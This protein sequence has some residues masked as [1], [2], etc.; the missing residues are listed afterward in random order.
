MNIILRQD[1]TLPHY[2]RYLRNHLD[3]RQIDRHG[4][5]EWSAR[6]PHNTFRFFLMEICR[7]TGL[8]DPTCISGDVRNRIT[9]VCAIIIPEIFETGNR[10]SEQTVSFLRVVGRTLNFSLESAHLSTFFSLLL[11]LCYYLLC[12]LFIIIYHLLKLK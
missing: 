9:R 1:E 5:T 11:I 7:I 4:P 8:L 10:M 2:F 12:Y 6:S 3:Q